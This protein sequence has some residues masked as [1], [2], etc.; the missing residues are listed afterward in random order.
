MV[1]SLEIAFNRE[2]RDILKLQVEAYSFCLH[3]EWRRVLPSLLL[4]THK[5][6]SRQKGFQ[7]YHMLKKVKMLGGVG[8]YHLNYN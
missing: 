8:K 3:N 7:N 1:P 6:Q 4:N 2:R 5:K